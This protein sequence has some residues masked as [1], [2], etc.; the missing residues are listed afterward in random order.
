MT[1]SVE[2][3][4]MLLAAFIFNTI[5]SKTLEI[6]SGFFF[7]VMAAFYVMSFVLLLSVNRYSRL[8]VFLILLMIEAVVVY[9]H[10]F[11]YSRV[12]FLT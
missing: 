5:Y 8:S 3:L 10:L 1:S 2:V 4:C 7:L 6:A 11:Y 12:T 9:V